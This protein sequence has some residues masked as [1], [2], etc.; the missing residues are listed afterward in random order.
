MKVIDIYIISE[1]PVFFTLLEMMFL[2]YIDE[3]VIEQYH[4]FLSLKEAEG[5]IPPDL[6]VLDD[7]VAGAA[8]M[9]IVS[10]FRTKRRLNSTICFF[11]EDVHDIEEK[12]L[13]RGAD[14]FFT[15]PFKPVEVV[16]K[17]VD[18]ILSPKQKISHETLHSRL[19]FRQ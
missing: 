11:S 10:W 17:M 4:S 1:D 8:S 3:V 18:M 2:Y 13:H 7:I 16:E 12:A 9:E 15:K 6:I 19:K 14:Y 5:K